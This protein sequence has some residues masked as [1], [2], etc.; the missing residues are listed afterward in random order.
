LELN[1][2]QTIRSIYDTENNELKAQFGWTIKNNRNYGVVAVHSRS[3]PRDLLMAAFQLEL[4]ILNDSTSIRQEVL[5]DRLK[6][7]GWNTD[8]HL[9]APDEFSFT[10]N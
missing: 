2:C 3:T 8:S 9:L 4:N 10:T 5:L 7:A 1:D 6:N